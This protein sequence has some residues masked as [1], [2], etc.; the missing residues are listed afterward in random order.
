[1]SNFQRHLNII[2]AGERGHSGL[3]MRKALEITWAVISAQLRPT[4]SYR[5]RGSGFGLRISKVRSRAGDSHHVESEEE[6][7]PK[8]CDAKG[9]LSDE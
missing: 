8:D 6:V 4:Q 7:Q 1:M 2:P 3:G 5:V 9:H